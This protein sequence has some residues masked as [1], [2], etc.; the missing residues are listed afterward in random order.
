MPTKNKKVKKKKKQVV[1]IHIYVYQ[2]SWTYP[3]VPINKYL[4]CTC[5]NSITSSPCPVHK[6]YSPIIT[7]Y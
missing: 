5:N 1:E 3:N 4:Q 6:P 2:D 7:T